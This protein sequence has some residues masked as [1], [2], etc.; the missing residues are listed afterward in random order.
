MQQRPEEVELGCRHPS[1]TKSIHIRKVD[2]VNRST[3]SRAIKASIGWPSRRLIAATAREVTCDP[4]AATWSAAIDAE[5]TTFTLFDVR[6][7]DRYLHSHIREPLSAADNGP[8]SRRPARRRWRRI[9]VL[10]RW[11]QQARLPAD[12][13]GHGLRDDRPRRRHRSTAQGFKAGD[14]ASLEQAIQAGVTYTNM[15]TPTFP[16][17]EIRGQISARR[18]SGH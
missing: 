3:S 16:N 4:G 6:A 8:H 9:R 7:T 12:H 13:V 18:H 11:G 2:R 14:L 1:N 10:L 17:G 15:H 5:P